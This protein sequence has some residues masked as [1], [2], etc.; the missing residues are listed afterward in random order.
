MEWVDNSWTANFKAEVVRDNELVRKQLA[1]YTNILNEGITDRI[2]KRVSNDPMLLEACMSRIDSTDTGYK[3]QV[4][5]AVL[6]C[7]TVELPEVKTNG[8]E[9]NKDQLDAARAIITDVVNDQFPDS[10]VDQIEEMDSVKLEGLRAAAITNL[11]RDYT[12]RSTMWG[13]MMDTLEDP[14]ALLAIANVEGTRMV[15][16]IKAAEA[17]GKLIIKQDKE[18]AAGLQ[19][20]QD[21]P[22][23]GEE[24]EPSLEEETS[25]TPVVDAAAADDLAAPAVEDDATVT[26]PVVDGETTPP[27]E[28]DEF[29]IPD[30]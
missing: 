28:D 23:P 27:A 11:M 4:L 9:L 18:S 24:E 20:A 15:A 29:A 22:L 8:V 10:L 19:E 12:K 16:I 3:S 2:V 21:A 17:L 26:D 14:E 1:W 30:V 6:T 7:L 5:E 13:E 25:E